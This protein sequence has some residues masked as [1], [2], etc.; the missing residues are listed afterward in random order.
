[1]SECKY[2][3][4]TKRPWGACSCNVIECR[5]PEAVEDSTSMQ[6]EHFKGFDGA[7][8]AVTKD[9]QII[10]NAGYIERRARFCNSNCPYYKEG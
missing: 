2:K 9:W 7:R 1:M 3:T 6:W 5:A 4:Q 10:E 8:F